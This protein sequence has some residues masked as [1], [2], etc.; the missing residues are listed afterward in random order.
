M[1]RLIDVRRSERVKPPRLAV[2]Y[3]PAPISRSAGR[4]DVFQELLEQLRVLDQAPRPEELVL[5]PLTGGRSKAAGVF[6]VR[7]QA[8]EDTAHRLQVHRI[9]E[10]DSA[11]AVDDLILDAADRFVATTGRAFHIASATVSPKPS[12]RLFWTTTSAIAAGS[13]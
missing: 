6:V 10:Q 13:R 2:G 7:Q 1:T 12:A 9:V 4:A 11:L 8:H 3:Q 5:Y